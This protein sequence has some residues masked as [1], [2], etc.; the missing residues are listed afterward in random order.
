ME[1]D[2][3]VLEIRWHGRGGQGVITAGKLIG[4]AA[5]G[6]GKY[7]QALPDYGAERM[8]APIR[9]YTRISPKRIQVHCQ[10][11][12]PD[13]VMVA[14]S[15]LLGVVDVTE[16][17]KDDGIL[18]VNT[19]LSP[20]AVRKRLGHYRG[21]VYTVDATGIALDTI[22]RNIPNSPMLGALIKATNIVDRDAMAYKMESKFKALFRPPIVA[23]N[24]QALKR[25]LEE[26]QVG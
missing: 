13:V 16:G 5:M 25:A 11:T 20:E 8:G 22:G 14:D 10:V 26:T 24:I 19:N 3:W 1:N 9:A 17:L 7:F 12:N 18:V 6:E 15:T 23:A 4:E 21:Q 2:D